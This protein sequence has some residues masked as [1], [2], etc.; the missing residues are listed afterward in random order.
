M[1]AKLNGLITNILVRPKKRDGVVQKDQ[2][3]QPIMERKLMVLDLEDEQAE[4]PYKINFDKD[5]EETVQSLLR[6]QV[7]AI[8][9]VHQF[10]KF[11]FFRLV[12]FEG[13]A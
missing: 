6:Q 4:N 12:A 1:Q 5:Q 3:G 7:D 13:L 10:N 11:T 9:S 2:Q 8:I